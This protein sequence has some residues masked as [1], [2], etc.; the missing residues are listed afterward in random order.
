[1]MWVGGR[2]LCKTSKSSFDMGG[3]KLNHMRVRLAS[4]CRSC[5]CTLMLEGHSFC[6]GIGH[7]R[8]VCGRGFGLEIEE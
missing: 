7:G 4:L 2:Y 8:R 6:E 5:Q 3:S 1:M